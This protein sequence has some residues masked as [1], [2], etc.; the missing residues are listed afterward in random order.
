MWEVLWTLI[1]RTYGYQHRLEK[2]E[3]SP[4]SPTAPGELTP[5]NQLPLGA[6]SLR[7]KNSNENMLG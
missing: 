5:R 7:D 6:K 2:A 3:A 4:T 1:G